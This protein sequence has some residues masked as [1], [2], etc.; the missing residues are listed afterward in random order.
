MLTI[1]NRFF[2][3]FFCCFIT[4]A[5]SANETKNDPNSLTKQDI[6]EWQLV[7]ITYLPDIPLDDLTLYTRL[8]EIKNISVKS[9]DS[10]LILDENHIINVHQVTDNLS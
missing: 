6:T 4:L 9:S 1:L 2:V 7:D 3:L 5:V 10:K 8:N